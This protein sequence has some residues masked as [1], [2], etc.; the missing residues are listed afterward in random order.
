MHYGKEEG[1]TYTYYATSGTGVYTASPHPLPCSIPLGI[2]QEE[3]EWRAGECR[4]GLRYPI[5]TWCTPCIR[6]HTL[7]HVVYYKGTQPTPMRSRGTHP[8][9]TG[10]MGTP[11]TMLHSR[12]P[13]TSGIPQL[14]GEE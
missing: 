9:Y 2:H 14:Q 5:P 13:T 12:V 7:P 4:R 11:S 6:P 1:S 3:E 10:G 8:V